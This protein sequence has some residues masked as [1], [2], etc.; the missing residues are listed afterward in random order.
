MSSKADMLIRRYSE[1]LIV[2]AASFAAAAFIML[3]ILL[4]VRPD[5]LIGAAFCHQ[6]EAR[7]PLSG[8]PF[9]Y[10]CSGLFSGIFCGI[11]FT[12]LRRNYG[13]V[14]SLQTV[15][16]IA[17]SLI[18]F[19]AD[20]INKT[21]YIPIRFYQERPVI[22]FLSAYPLGFFLSKMIVSISGSLF[23]LHSASGSRNIFITGISL[24]GSCL[25]AYLAI[26]SGNLLILRISGFLI[27]AGSLFFLM[28]LY[29]ILIKC[30]GMLLN[31]DISLK[32]SLSASIFP[33]LCQICVLGGLHLYLFN[34]DQLFS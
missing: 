29:S 13:S 23:G 28:I 34:F 22:R 25:I 10:R 33:A 5:Q 24:F 15:F 30:I 6:M 8:F 19:L 21:E 27:S 18:I 12:L 4:R 2:L 14:L 31:H 16:P 9:C 26:F 3:C 11:I 1:S 17:A 7:S 20:I 32:S